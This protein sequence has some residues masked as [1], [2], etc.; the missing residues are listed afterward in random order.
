MGNQ[1]SCGN[2]MNGA[3]KIHAIF[4]TFLTDLA[5]PGKSVTA[6]ARVN[7]SKI[8]QFISSL[9]SI[10]NFEFASASFFIKYDDN[11]LPNK[12][13]LESFIQ[14]HFPYASIEEDRLEFYDDWK[15]A[16]SQ[17]S[18]EIDLI[19]L[20]TNHD[21]A[22]VA[23]SVDYFRDFALDVYMNG[24]RSI[25]KI[26]HWPEDIA[27]YGLK[28]QVSFATGQTVF[29]SLADMCVGTA[30]VSSDLFKEWWEEDFTGGKR[31]IRPDNPFEPVVTFVPAK[32]L[33]PPFELFRH[34][35]GYSHVG[36][37]SPSA[38]PLRP[39]CS[40]QNHL[41][42]HQDWVHTSFALNEFNGDLPYFAYPIPSLKPQVNREL[43]L[44]ASAYRINLLNLYRLLP[45]GSLNNRARSFFFAIFFLFTNKHF[46]TRIPESL[47]FFAVESTKALYRFLRNRRGFFWLNHLRRLI[48]FYRIG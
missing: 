23:N 37:S 29:G 7:V 20:Q 32:T 10:K 3:V 43:F 25:G 30:L 4:S 38:K 11:Y 6:P 46:Y 26:T 5:L 2:E 24:D 35:D 27:R 12:A 45:A 47:R 42:T 39:C 18:S 9:H 21:H 15:F 28:S 41:I 17:I 48:D 8:D 22:Y 44:L 19:F 40:I 16:A 33:L 1:N 36:I 14:I 13:I 34:L 31:I